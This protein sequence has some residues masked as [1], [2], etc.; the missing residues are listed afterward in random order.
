MVFIQFIPT[1]RANPPK[2]GE[3]LTRHEVRLLLQRACYDCHSNETK[4]PSY[5]YVAPLS[6]YFINEVHEGRRKLNFSNWSR[7][8]KEKQDHMLNEIWLEV[9]DGD[10]PPEKYLWLHSDAELTASDRDLI[11][12]WTHGLLSEF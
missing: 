9:E 10:M 3:I 2:A 8:P 5:S 11:Y 4:W 7:M 1:K 6:W 12:R